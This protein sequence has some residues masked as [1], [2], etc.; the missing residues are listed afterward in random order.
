MSLA[1]E[2]QLSYLPPASS[3]LEL[4]SFGWHSSCPLSPSW[5]EGSLEGST[6]TSSQPPTEFVHCLLE[7]NENIRK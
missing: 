2:R 4:P 6:N 5:Q 3:H 7:I 1:S